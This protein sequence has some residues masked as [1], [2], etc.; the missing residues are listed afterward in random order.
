MESPATILHQT[1]SP[2]GP[3]NLEFQ[4]GMAHHRKNSMRIR[5]PP[6]ERNLDGL[7]RSP[8]RP[9]QKATRINII[10]SM[11]WRLDRTTPIKE[12]DWLTLDKPE[13]VLPEEFYHVREISPRQCLKVT[14]IEG[15]RTQRDWRGSQGRTQFY[16]RH[17][18]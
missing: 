7:A 4:Q 15:Y 13:R 8:P 17:G 14:F 18:N 11:P 9:H 10:A 5:Q 12:R 6:L 2:Q 16:S 3:W 1:T